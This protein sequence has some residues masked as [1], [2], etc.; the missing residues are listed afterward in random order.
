MRILCRS[1]IALRMSA[2]RSARAGTG[3]PLADIERCRIEIVAQRVGDNQGH[4]GQ[5]ALGRLL[6]PGITSATAALDS[7]GNGFRPLPA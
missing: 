1:R 5:H 7:D 6:E 4:L 2:G 3:A